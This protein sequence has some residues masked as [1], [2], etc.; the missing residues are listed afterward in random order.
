ML[1]P[2]CMLFVV[3]ILLAS[4]LWTDICAFG[5]FS[6][7]V[8]DKDLAIGAHSSCRCLGSLS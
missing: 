2:L 1:T 6:P 5:I 4:L 3:L 8:N 7:A